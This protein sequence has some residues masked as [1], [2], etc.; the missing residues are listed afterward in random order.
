MPTKR[1][2]PKKGTGKKPK[3][4]A[5]VYILTR[6]PKIPLALNMLH[7]QMLEQL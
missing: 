1:K 7:L 4:Q 6:I 5:D 3:G 2:D